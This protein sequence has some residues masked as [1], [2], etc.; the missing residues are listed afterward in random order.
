M[1]QKLGNNYW[2]A[3]SHEMDHAYH[4]P[5]EEPIGFKKL[6]EYFSKNNGTELAARG[7]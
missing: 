3:I 7:S 6:N 4:M 5:T 1:K 2:R